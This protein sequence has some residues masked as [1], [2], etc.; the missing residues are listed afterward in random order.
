MQWYIWQLTIFSQ[1]L[2]WSWILM[3]DVC[4][5]SQLK[6]PMLELNFNITL[7]CRPGKSGKALGSTLL[8]RPEALCDSAPYNWHL[9]PTQL[10]QEPGRRQLNY[11]LIHQVV[12]SGN[13]LSY[14]ASWSD[15]HT[16]FVWYESSTSTHNTHL[17]HTTRVRGRKGRSDPSWYGTKPKVR[18][19]SCSYLYNND[20]DFGLLFF[21]YK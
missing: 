14:N 9:T 17:A 2:K 6:N 21:W 3:A 11:G 12:H 10:M 13:V 20:I 15:I 1:I 5:L 8:R 7:R 19:M 16:V 4:T 18:G